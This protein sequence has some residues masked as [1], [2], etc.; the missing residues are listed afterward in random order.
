MVGSIDGLRQRIRILILKTIAYAR[1][2]PK[3]EVG[4]VFVNQLLRAITSIGANFE[5][6]SEAQ[7]VRDIIYKLSVVK[8]EAKESKYWLELTCEAFP[9]LTVRGKILIQEVGE[10]IKIFSSIIQ[11]KKAEH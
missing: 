7:T 5:E 8:K 2:I 6:A 4:R 11:K 1:D 3:D 9:E 10:L